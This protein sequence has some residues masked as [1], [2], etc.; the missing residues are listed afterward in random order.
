[1]IAASRSRGR[2]RGAMLWAL[3]WG[4]GAWAYDAVQAAGD[5]DSLLKPGPEVA[6]TTGDVQPAAL[7]TETGRGPG[8]PLEREPVVGRPVPLVAAAG[9]AE[10]THGGRSTAVVQPSAG[11]ALSDWRVIAALGAA[12]VL[13]ASFKLFARR[14]G[15]SVPPPDVFEVL[16]AAPLAG[17]HAVKIVRFGPKTLLVGVSS[18]G[19]TTLAEIADPQATARIAAACRGGQRPLQA[20]ATRTGHTGVEAAAQAAGTFTAKSTGQVVAEPQATG[21]AA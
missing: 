6:G 7:V 16:A 2:L 12:F 13:L 10:M 11:P 9:A 15:A 8:V 5:L 18:A 21:D 4:F 1:M 19:C 17:Q 3:A 14:G 20:L